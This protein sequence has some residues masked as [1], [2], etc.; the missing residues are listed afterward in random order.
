[1]VCQAIASWIVH[2]PAAPGSLSQIPPPAQHVIY[3]LTGVN[4]Y[5]PILLHSG[6]TVILSAQPPYR[7]HQLNYKY[8]LSELCK[9]MLYW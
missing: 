9:V 3:T 7:S 1:M 8:N 5:I 4:S 6:T 2:S